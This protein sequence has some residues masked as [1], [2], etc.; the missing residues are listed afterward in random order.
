MPVVSYASV[1]DSPPLVAVGCSPGAFTCKLVTRSHAFSLSL[2]GSSH[3]QSVGRLAEVRG[4]SVRD[5][6]KAVG[7]AHAK[8]TKLAVPVI[9][10]AEATL[11]C[12][13]ERT[14][15]TGDH[16]LII[17]R[18]VSAR[19]NSSFSDFWDFSRYEPILYTGWKQGMTTYPGTSGRK[20]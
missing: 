9:E 3:I 1:S 5:K 2:L 20:R 6:L 7:L 13:V 15:N 18:V 12:K 17:G 16:R 14:V 11:E 4:S 10:A 19:A 8:G